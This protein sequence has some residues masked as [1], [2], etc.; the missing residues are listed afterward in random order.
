VKTPLEPAPVEPAPLLETVVPLE[1]PLVPPLD[2]PPPVDPPGL[3][4]DPLRPPVEEEPPPT[5]EVEPPSCV[6]LTGWSHPASELQSSNV[7]STCKADS[8]RIVVAPPSLSSRRG[9]GDTQAV[10]G[11]PA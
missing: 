8:Q 5:V 9:C 6:S 11:D 4:E 1:L 2:H 3:P 10:E 7:P